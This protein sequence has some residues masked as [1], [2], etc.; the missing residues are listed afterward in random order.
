MTKR[1]KEPIDFEIWEIFFIPDFLSPDRVPLFLSRSRCP[2][3]LFSLNLNLS[4]A[5]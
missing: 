1:T 3:S 5:E 2:L 4:S